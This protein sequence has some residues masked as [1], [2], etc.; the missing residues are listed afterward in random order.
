MPLKI[1][2]KGIEFRIFCMR[3]SN[4]NKNSKP[5]PEP[6][7]SQCTFE[8]I[9]ND[10]GSKIYT[11]SI[12]IDAMKASGTLAA[13]AHAMFIIILAAATPFLCLFL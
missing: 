2:A 8:D 1:G 9:P 11:S 13:V 3:F 12:F 5:E 10:E 4:E 6:K 7:R